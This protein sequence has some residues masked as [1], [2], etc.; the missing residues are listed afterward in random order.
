MFETT[1]R[2]DLPRR[3]SRRSNIPRICS[4]LR[5][6]VSRYEAPSS[7]AFLRGKLSDRIGASEPAD[8]SGTR[9][10]IQGKLTDIVY[11]WNPAA[12]ARA[13]TSRID[14][15]CKGDYQY[16]ERPI[17]SRRIAQ[18]RLHS[19][20]NLRST[21]VIPERIEAKWWRRFEYS[22]IIT[23]DEAEASEF[24]DWRD[25]YLSKT[26][27]TSRLYLQNVNGDLKHIMEFLD[28]QKERVRGMKS[29][30]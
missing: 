11:K 12:R 17:P 22:H 10:W 8:E 16:V 7:F 30:N 23:C 3:N 18:R 9:D 24:L 28:E 27:S 1:V 6:E 29:I 14:I 5:Y 25:V 21:P 20:L 15:T 26:K 13:H 2:G 4:R 19:Y